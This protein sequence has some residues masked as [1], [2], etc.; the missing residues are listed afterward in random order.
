M[1]YQIRY[2][3]DGGTWQTL[4]DTIT[5]Q[6]PNGDVRIREATGMLANLH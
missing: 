1:T 4:G 6:G 3:I 5:A 2:R